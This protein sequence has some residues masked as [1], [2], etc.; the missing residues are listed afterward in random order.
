MK[1]TAKRSTVV[2]SVLALLLGAGVAFAAWTST[3]LGSADVTASEAQDLVVT[4]SSPTGLYPTGNVTVSVTVANPNP[5]KVELESIV[6]VDTETAAVGCDATVVTAADL[7]DLGDVLPAN[8]VTPVSNDVVV[9]MSNA[10]T[11]E[12]QNAE[13]TVNFVASGS[14]TS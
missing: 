13:F 1:R 12:C 11:D 5:Y 6:F 8:S 4:T 7:S 14:S 10:A 2:G 3:G 9:S